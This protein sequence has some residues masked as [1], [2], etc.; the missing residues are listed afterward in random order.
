[1]RVLA[2]PGG[3]K[4]LG[5]VGDVVED[6]AAVS[7]EAYARKVWGASASLDPFTYHSLSLATIL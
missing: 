7:R 1:M 3:E 2:E 5:L 4:R 6:V